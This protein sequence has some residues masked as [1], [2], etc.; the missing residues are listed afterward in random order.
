MKHATL[1]LYLDYTLTYNPASANIP[2]GVVTP[3]ALTGFLS[4]AE[5]AGAVPGVYSDTVILTIEP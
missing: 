5:Y 4:G 1:A 3:I 2:K